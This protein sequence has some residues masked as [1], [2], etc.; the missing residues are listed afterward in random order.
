MHNHQIATL[1]AVYA[2]W[3]FARIKGCGWG[4]AGIIWLYSLIS[5]IPLD[6]IKFAI[7]YVLSGNAW[8]YL[9]ERKVKKP[10][11]WDL[12]WLMQYSTGLS[13]LCYFPMSDC[14]HDKEGL[15][16]RGKGSSMGYCAE[17]ASWPPTSWHYESVQRQEQLP[18]AIGDR[19]A[20]QEASWDRKVCGSHPIN[21]SHD[22]EAVR[23]SNLAILDRSSQATWAAHSQGSRRV[24]GEAEGAWHR[25]HAAALHSVAAAQNPTWFLATKTKSSLSIYLCLSLIYMW[26]A[27]LLFLL[28]VLAFLLTR[29]QCSWCE[30][31][32]I[33]WWRTSLS[34]L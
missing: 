25:H 15:R 17:D 9:F 32:E 2:N 31:K 1:V 8:T 5:F 14:L 24:G 21:L 11:L 13:L 3:S 28:L 16:Q 4:W 33:S 30:K 18:R 20:G 12:C 10:S 22:H 19:R 6:W 26:S 29:G 7:R 23:D 27:H 34:S